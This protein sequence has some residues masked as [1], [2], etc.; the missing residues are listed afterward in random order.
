LKVL[1]LVLVCAAA[2]CGSPTSPSGEDAPYSRS[3]LRV[4]TGATVVNGSNVTV[5]YTGWLYSSSR[6]ENKGTRFDSGTIRFIV[7]TNQVIRGMD[8]GV[9]GMRVGGLRRIVVSS[10]LG[11]GSLGS[12]PVPPNSAMVFE[13][14]VVDSQS[15]AR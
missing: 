11:Y 10:E 13:V 2:A 6:T 4:G 5:N 3:D 12:G 1:A 15:Q 7:G 8:S 14:E 9:V